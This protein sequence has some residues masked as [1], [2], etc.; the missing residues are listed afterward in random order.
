MAEFG[1]KQYIKKYTYPANPLRKCKQST[2]DLLFTNDSDLVSHV[3]VVEN[4]SPSCDHFAI[5]AH[6]NISLEKQK[7]EPH[8]YQDF[9]E[10]NL[11]KINSELQ[12]V[13]WNAILDSTADINSIFNSFISCVSKAVDKHAPFRVFNCRPKISRK[14]K[15]MLCQKSVLYQMYSQTH[16]PNIFLQYQQLYAKI[17]VHLNTESDIWIQKTISNSSD[18]STFCKNIKSRCATQDSNVLV[19]ENGIAITNDKD[20]AEQFN[21]YFSNIFMPKTTPTYGV[22][23]L[24]H[25]LDAVKITLTDVLRT[26][27]SYNIK[28][29]T[30]IR[31]IPNKVLKHSASLFAVLLHK[32]F[33]TIS[34]RCEIPSL[35]KIS[36]ICPILKPGKP[37]HLLS[38][39]R[40]LALWLT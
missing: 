30:G 23:S 5:S 32:L 25:K 16:D 2:I 6:I 36:Q 13:D 11:E 27:L 29:S 38:S 14:T 19:N 34:D 4:I 39:R 22:C 15:E 20:I 28:K 7:Y 26:L 21:S 18:F 17:G 9:S 1:F 35:M 8:K 40:P 3:D 37:K 31:S 10:N 12:N 33:T 24:E